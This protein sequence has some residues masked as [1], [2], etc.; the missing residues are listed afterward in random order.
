MH[1]ARAVREVGFV[2][3]AEQ[4]ERDARRERLAVLGRRVVPRPKEIVGVL[5][6]DADEPLER[7]RAGIRLRDGWRRLWRG[8]G[9]GGL[10]EGGGGEMSGGGLRP[11]RHAP[12][13]DGP[14]AGGG[15]RRRGGALG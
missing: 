15:G 4:A 9:G 10:G 5:A 14:R 8:R 2:P 7:D 3:P 1:E 12:R 6:L 13:G 11:R